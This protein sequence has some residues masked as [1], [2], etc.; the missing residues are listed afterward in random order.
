MT[1]EIRAASEDVQKYLNRSGQWQNNWNHDLQHKGF[2]GFLS[3]R[4]S[5]GTWNL[6]DYN[7]YVKFRAEVSFAHAGSMMGWFVDAMPLQSQYNTIGGPM[8]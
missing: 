8:G 5:D 1:I 2:T 3:P 4:K 6:T 7:P